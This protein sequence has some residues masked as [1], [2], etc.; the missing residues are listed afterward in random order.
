MILLLDNPMKLLSDVPK[1]ENTREAILYWA[2][3][4][5]QKESCAHLQL[6]KELLKLRGKVRNKKK[7]TYDQLEKLVRWKL[8]RQLANIRNNCPDCV[9]EQTSAAFKTADVQESIDHLSQLK[10]IGV[11]IG[12]AILHF[13]HEDN[14]PIFDQHALRAVGKEYDERLW[15]CYVDYCRDIARDNNVCMRTLDRALFRFG[16]VLSVLQ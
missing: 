11:S 3:K 6:E 2:K 1:T 13:F 16:Y 5:K 12:S 10:G 4:Y 7:L 14:F 9:V 8:P 15:K